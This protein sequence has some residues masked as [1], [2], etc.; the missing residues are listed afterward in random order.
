MS[1]RRHRPRRRL[2]L[3]DAELSRRACEP[4]PALAVC[5]HVRFQALRATERLLTGSAWR[6]PRKRLHLRHSVR[7]LVVVGRLCPSKS[8]LRR[9]IECP[10]E[11][12]YASPGNEIASLSCTV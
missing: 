9:G 6:I 3:V 2:A 11:G 10:R 8:T 1:V 4:L 7:C 5:Q 12:G